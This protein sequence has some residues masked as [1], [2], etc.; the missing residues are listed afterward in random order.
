MSKKVQV[1]MSDDLFNWIVEESKSMSINI[2]ATVNV[3]V[4]EVRRN[5]ENTK[6]LS[7]AMAQFSKIPPEHIEKA[8]KKE[9]FIIEEASQF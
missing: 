8:I 3:L 2:S 5:R 6:A 4:S 7:S 1:T 9:Q